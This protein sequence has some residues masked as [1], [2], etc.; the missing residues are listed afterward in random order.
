MVHND[1]KLVINTD[2]VGGDRDK[3]DDVSEDE[4]NIDG[5]DQCGHGNNDDDDDETKNVPVLTVGTKFPR[6]QDKSLNRRKI[7]TRGRCHS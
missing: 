4:D 2:H 1:K 3:S 5:N 6:L 7:N